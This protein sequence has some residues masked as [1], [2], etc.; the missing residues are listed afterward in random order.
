[1][2]GEMSV[3]IETQEALNEWG[4]AGGP[5]IPEHPKL[6]TYRQRRIAHLLKLCVISAAACDSQRVITL[7]HFAE[8]L[9]WL[10]EL[11][12]AMPDVFKS[13]KLGGSARAIEE[14]YH[15][16]YEKFHKL[17]KKHVPEH[18]IIAFLQER[19]PLHDVDRILE[20]MERAHLLEKGIAGNGVGYK[21]RVKAA[22]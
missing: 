13:L 16:V 8:A 17:G 2:Y 15:F 5:P 11:E 3:D 10:V 14:C 9:D 1:M 20:S 19:V 22:E 6:V 21:P 7:E 12:R 18:L 4:R